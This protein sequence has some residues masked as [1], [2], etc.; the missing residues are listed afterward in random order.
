M[1]KKIIDNLS[2]KEKAKKS[3]LDMILDKN[4][5]VM[6]SMCDYSSRPRTEPGAG[7]SVQVVRSRGRGRADN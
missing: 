4:S 7:V 6:K 2:N 5:E 3:N 1:V